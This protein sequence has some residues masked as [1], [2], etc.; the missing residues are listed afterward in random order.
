MFK[1]HQWLFL[2]SFIRKITNDGYFETTLVESNNFFVTST[3]HENSYLAII[4]RK[5][6]N[7]FRFMDDLCLQI[8]KSIFCNI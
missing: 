3:D 7:D 5:K 1:D 2:I 6:S 8:L 4:L